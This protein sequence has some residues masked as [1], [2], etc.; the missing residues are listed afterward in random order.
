[1]NTIKFT[2]RS[3]PAL[4][5]AAAAISACHDPDERQGVTAEA[6]AEECSF[7]TGNLNKLHCR[8]SIYRLLSDPRSYFG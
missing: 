8:V 1:M 2:N 6:T 3:L 7:R 4:L 5:L